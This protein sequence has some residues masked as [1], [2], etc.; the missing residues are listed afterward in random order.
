MLD[1]FKLNALV[2]QVSVFDSIN[3]QGG[4]SRRVRRLGEFHPTM[5][6]ATAT[7]AQDLDDPL[8]GNS[9]DDAEKARQHPLGLCAKSLC[10]NCFSAA[11]RPCYMNNLTFCLHSNAY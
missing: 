4:Y 5:A 1:V 8:Y 3:S 2:C 7:D 6:A 11:F 10:N 9:Q